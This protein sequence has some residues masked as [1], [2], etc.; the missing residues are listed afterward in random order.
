MEETLREGF[1]LSQGMKAAVQRFAD[2]EAPLE[3]QVQGCNPGARSLADMEPVDAVVSEL[4]EV[5]VDVPAAWIVSTS[6]VSH[7]GLGEGF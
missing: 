2:P 7:C 4:A 3:A 5:G 1:L 6:F